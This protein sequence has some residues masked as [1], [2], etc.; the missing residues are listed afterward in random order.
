MDEDAGR[1]SQTAVSIRK[2]GKSMQCSVYHGIFFRG[3]SQ[4][5]VVGFLSRS[6]DNA[7]TTV[8]IEFYKPASCVFST[9][10]DD[11]FHCDTANRSGGRAVFFDYI[12][13]RSISGHIVFIIRPFFSAITGR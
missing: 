6:K 1:F 8:L 7:Q 11:F 10:A 9:F 2:F 12:S 5:L 13:R 4:C 3:H